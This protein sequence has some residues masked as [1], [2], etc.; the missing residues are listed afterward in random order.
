M[1]GEK[2]NITAEFLNENSRGMVNSAAAMLRLLDDLDSA[3][4][5]TQ[6]GKDGSYVDC[7]MEEHKGITNEMA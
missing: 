3:T 7:Y 6:V 1:L 4:D 2:A 5:E